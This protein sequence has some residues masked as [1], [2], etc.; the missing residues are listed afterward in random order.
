MSF[1]L[2]ENN[3]KTRHCFLQVDS[4]SRW[5]SLSRQTHDMFWKSNRWQVVQFRCSICTL[6]L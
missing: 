2:T 1:F 4:N 5:Y 3:L 6:S